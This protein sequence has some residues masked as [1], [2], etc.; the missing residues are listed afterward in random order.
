MDYNANTNPRSL[1][2]YRVYLRFL[3]GL[4]LDPGLSGKVEAS[5]VVQQ[6][7]L[8]AQEKMHQFKGQTEPELL[9]WLRKILINNATDALRKFGRER[10]LE[11]DLEANLEE[12]SARLEAWLAIEQSS[13]SEVA[14]RN[15]QLLRLSEA[16]GQLP[17]DQR[18]A[19]VLHHLQGWSPDAISKHLGRSKAAVG[20]LVRRGILRLRELLRDRP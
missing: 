6:T 8:R 3:A 7:L 11:Q 14:M 20:G 16:L 2:S 4:L 15:E 9:G 12:S 13:P 10:D 17:D 18:T 19:V 1:E 5:D